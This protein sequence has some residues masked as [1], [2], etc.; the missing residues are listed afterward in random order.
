MTLATTRAPRADTDSQGVNDPKTLRS[1][2][3]R[4]QRTGSFTPCS[5]LLS[6]ARSQDRTAEGAVL[7][8]GQLA[9]GVIFCPS[10]A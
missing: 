4:E 9:S 10:S 7:Q 1:G 3:R 8:A 5:L 6:S 2:D